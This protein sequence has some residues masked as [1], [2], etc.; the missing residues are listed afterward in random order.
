MHTSRTIAAILGF[1]VSVFVGTTRAED[2]PKSVQTIW[3]AGQTYETIVKMT[4]DVSNATL[5]AASE[6]KGSYT[7]PHLV[8]KPVL[9]IRSDDIQKSGVNYFGKR[10][11]VEPKQLVEGIENVKWTYKYGWAAP[12]QWTAMWRMSK[13][14]D[15]QEWKR[16]NKELATQIKKNGVAVESFSVF[17]TDDH[18][19]VDFNPVSDALLLSWSESSVEN[20]HNGGQDDLIAKAFLAKMSDGSEILVKGRGNLPRAN[21]EIQR[22]I[23]AECNVLASVLYDDPSGNR[24]SLLKNKK[25]WKIDAGAVNKGLLFYGGMNSLIY[26]EGTLTVRREPIEMSEIRNNGLKPF[27]GEKILVVNSNGAKAGYNIGGRWEPFPLTI[28]FAKRDDPNA[29]MMEFWFDSDHNVLRY[30]KV[31]IVKPDYDGDIP[32]P[33]LGKATSALKGTVKGRVSFELEYWT[34]VNQPLPDLD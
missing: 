10:T 18:K 27:N 15:V 33:R 29:N 28:D 9:R 14:K 21:H 2:T 34:A 24:R 16:Q 8:F 12:W 1:A 3:N 32:N 20:F 11:Y 19:E 7:I 25:Q 5:A 6:Y 17:Y 13:N 23:V 4:I 31:R 26:F 22:K 30:A